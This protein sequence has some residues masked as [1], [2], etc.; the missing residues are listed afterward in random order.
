MILD[1]VCML[2]SDRPFRISGDCLWLPGQ[3]RRR[4]HTQDMQYIDLAFAVLQHA[5][6]L[7]VLQLSSIHVIC[8]NF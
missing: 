8:G 7:E 1:C 4:A 6:G 2:N 3:R 5:N